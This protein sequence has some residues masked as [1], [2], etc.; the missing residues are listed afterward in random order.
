MCIVQHTTARSVILWTVVL[1]PSLAQSTNSGSSRER[2]VIAGID[3]AQS[4]REA[5]L[6]GYSV[7]EHYTVHNSRFNKNAEIVVEAVFSKAAGKEYRVVSRSGSSVLQS[8]ILDKLLIE[9]AEMSRG[10]AWRQSR[11]ISANYDMKL[12]REEVKDG[13]LCALMELV[14]RVKSPHALEGFV[15]VDAK[16]YVLVRIEGKPTV[17]PSFIAG[18]PSITRE[19]QKLNGFAFAKRSQALS[20][21]ALLGKTELTIDYSGY[22]LAIL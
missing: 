3:E 17:S 18:R 1:L 14:P 8:R 20:N 19:Y 7:T 6:K 15:W 2:E 4:R 21:N 12:V 11:V 13:Q 9:E 22:K 5:N 16:D 10:P